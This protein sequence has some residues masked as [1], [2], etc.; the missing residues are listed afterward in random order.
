MTDEVQ[1]RVKAL[2]ITLERCATGYYDKS[3]A[4]HPSDAEV[5]VSKRTANALVDMDLATYNN[6][7]VP[8]AFMLTP[9]GIREGSAAAKAAAR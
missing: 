8:S 6:P 4:A 3:R 9:A 1:P 2:S 5:I 7:D